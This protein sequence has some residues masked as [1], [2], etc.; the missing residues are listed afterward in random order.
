LLDAART[1]VH[2]QAWEQVETDAREV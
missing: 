1:G 2:L